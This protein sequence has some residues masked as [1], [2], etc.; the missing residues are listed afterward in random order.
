MASRHTNLG[1]LAA[2]LVATV[3]GIGAFLVGTSAGR[4]V[5]IA[6]DAAGPAVVVLAPWKQQARGTPTAPRRDG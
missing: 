1:L 2:L 5:V 3:T 4:L 6:H